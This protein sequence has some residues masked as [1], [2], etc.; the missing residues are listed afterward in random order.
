MK[1]AMHRS[2]P[3]FFAGYRNRVE[4][5]LQTHLADCNA[6]E[7]LHQAINYSIF[8]GG[9]RIRPI[10]AYATADALG[11]DSNAVDA[12]ACAVEL[13][14]TYSLIHDDLPCM[15]DDSLRR[16]KPTTHVAFDEATATL[17]GDA[18]Q[19]MAF[20]LLSSAKHPAETVLKMVRELAKASGVAGMVAGQMIDLESMG[21]EI[22][23]DTLE[24]MHL[25]KTGALIG[26]SVKLAT[27]CCSHSDRQLDQLGL[28]AHNIG[29]AFQVQDDI[30]DV[31][32][33]SQI[34]GKKQGAD[35]CLGKSTYVSLY[36]LQG[37]KTKLAGLYE[38]S[39]TSLHALGAA[40]E[41]LRS[42]A[43]FVV[44]RSY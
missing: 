12:V 35:S 24:A 41:Q 9:K 15:D 26:A 22:D 16:G 42:L 13:I 28:F 6:P 19:A 39:I 40:A 38:A 33:S 14:H 34:M 5:K 37:A 21:V 36:G 8:N 1:I 23:A 25:H 32:G 10:L 4:Q 7:K 3:S 17:A 43:S 27:L 11:S 31:E 18:L 20:E 29:L 2:E 30:L 44:H